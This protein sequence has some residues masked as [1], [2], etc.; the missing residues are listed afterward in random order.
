MIV[1]KNDNR[2][3]QEQHAL[4]LL[5]LH[6][7]SSSLFSLA[8]AFLM[9]SMVPVSLIDSSIPLYYASAVTASVGSSRSGG[10]SATTTTIG[11]FAGDA[12][13]VTAVTTD[14]SNGGAVAAE[15]QWE[16]LHARVSVPKGRVGHAMTRGA[17]EASAVV[18]GGRRSAVNIWDFNEESYLN[19]TWVVFWEDEE[20]IWLPK[21]AEANALA[22]SARDEHSMATVMVTG[23]RRRVQAARHTAFNTVQARSQQSP[24]TPPPPHSAPSLGFPM[25]EPVVLLF[26]GKDHTGVLE[27]LWVFDPRSYVWAPLTRGPEHTVWPP[28]RHSHSAVAIDDSLYVYGGQALDGGP[29]DAEAGTVWEYHFIP[30]SGPDTNSSNSSNRDYHGMW[31]KHLPPKTQLSSYSVQQ[32]GLTARSSVASGGDSGV[33]NARNTT[34][35]NGTLPSSSS[36]PAHRYQHSACGRTGAGLPRGAMN[37]FG[38]LQLGP[39][40]KERSTT[41]DA[42]LNDFWQWN[43]DT[44][45]WHQPN[46]SGSTAPRSNKADPPGAA[47]RPPGL[48]EHV[49][50][51]LDDR[52]F[53][54]YGHTTMQQYPEVSVW[55]Y[56]ITD[57]ASGDGFWSVGV[58]S[59]ATATPSDS[60]PLARAGLAAVMVAARDNEAAVLVFG[61]ECHLS[62][63]LG[64]SFADSWLL[65]LQR[66][67]WQ[68]QTDARYPPLRLAHS[69]VQVQNGSEMLLFGGLSITH[70]F[71]D[72]LWSLSLDDTRRPLHEWTQIPVSAPD[73]LRGRLGHS[74]VV[75]QQPVGTVSG[76]HGS[77]GK[78]GRGEFG[79]EFMI[80]Y[81]G[82]HTVPTITTLDDMW[83][84]GA[85]SGNWSRVQH[86][87]SEVPGGLVSHSAVVMGDTK[88]MWVYGGIS[89]ASEEEEEG[90]GEPNRARRRSSKSNS[91]DAQSGIFGGLFSHAPLSTE[92]LN[93]NLWRCEFSFSAQASENLPAP[94]SCQWQR[95]VPQQSQLPRPRARHTAT[96]LTSNRGENAEKMIVFG[97][98]VMAG[99]G[100][101][102]SYDFTDEVWIFDCHKLQWMHARTYTPG[103]NGPVARWGHSATAIGADRLVI[104]GGFSHF[105][106]LDDVWL[107][108]LTDLSWTKISAVRS[109]DH[110]SRGA[111]TSVFHGHHLLVYGGT[112]LDL[113]PVEEDDITYLKPG[114][115][116]GSYSVD[117]SL[118]SCKRCPLGHYSTAA[119]ATTCNKC[120][121]ETTTAETG[122]AHETSC[123]LCQKGVCHGFP[124]LV[125]I[126]SGVDSADE[127]AEYRVSCE[128]GYFYSQSSR[129]SDL[130][131]WWIALPTTLGTSLVIAVAWLYVWRKLARPL[132]SVKRS[133]RKA[134]SEVNE[135]TTAWRIELDD[136]EMTGRLDTDSPG[137]FGEVWRARYL[138]H[139]VA[140]KKLRTIMLDLD[141]EALADFEREIQF[142]RSIRNPHIVLFYGAGTENGVPFLVT[143]LLSMG[144]LRTVLSNPS[145]ALPWPLRV[146]F[147]SHA[148]KGMKFLHALRP[149][150]LHRDLKSANLLVSDRWIVKIAD[151][152]TSTLYGAATK[153]RG[154]NGVRARAMTGASLNSLS[155]N[156]GDVEEW[157]VSDPHVE[158]ANLLVTETQGTLAFMAPEVHRDRKFGPSADVYAFGIVLWEIFTRSE[159]P[160]E[161]IRGPPAAVRNAVCAGARPRLPPGCPGSYRCLMEACW[162]PRRKDRPPFKAIVNVLDEAISAQCLDWPPPNDVFSS[163]NESESSS[164]SSSGGGVGSGG[165]E[166]SIVASGTTVAATSASEA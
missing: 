82:T 71:L 54:L 39:G 28:A 31:I 128:C 93:G 86:N 98:I 25:A 145:T 157:D 133:L 161:H 17:T 154:G 113:R 80:I 97:G 1:R 119:G 125:N 135:L 111:H 96:V 118:Q 81:G 46:A 68:R 60:Q 138:G 163:F 62:R 67:N 117:F 162:S 55:E 139:D 27:D 15:N 149:S 127:L 77:Y 136:V 2:N 85:S 91:K 148:A 11:R 142:M 99:A 83:S 94:Q 64:L 105:A 90:M 92:V 33:Y 4:T 115:N 35:G 122:A 153:R 9:V 88:S 23:G 156:A 41:T 76:S 13:F 61:G 107:F 51:A 40:A 66:F 102:S 59:S 143:E 134:R 19:D 43:A 73:S 129:C 45:L 144:A 152:G 120:P 57:A 5:L 131:W 155:I 109:P 110:L 7:V 29:P 65:Q 12:G 74:A 48:F 121:A 84:F 6:T 47:V 160:F 137:A 56:S 114:C 78:S 16:N 70:G 147:A 3:R 14:M 130:D 150:R 100:N 49:S 104:A 44:H 34:F 123:N 140:V 22:P 106:V 30:S 72:D 108:S 53:L 8:I 52:I 79:A 24:V 63:Y 37:I 159:Q 87:G 124:C 101:T 141:P 58:N 112:S 50:L 75:L 165:N 132:Q 146:Q 116:P 18:F 10:G 166:Q 126:T 69:A 26:G 38:G 151:F 164:A 42:P 32:S 36:V 89:S 95:V 103:S 20:I 158:T 21:A